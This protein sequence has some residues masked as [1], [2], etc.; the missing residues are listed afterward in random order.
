MVALEISAQRRP[1]SHQPGNA[2]IDPTYDFFPDAMELGVA[3]TGFACFAVSE[4]DLDSV[5]GF[6]SV[7]F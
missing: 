4:V 3:L 1:S 2:S 6:S 5:G 7:G